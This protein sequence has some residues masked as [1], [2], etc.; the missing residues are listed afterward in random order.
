MSNW[1][2]RF[3][4]M[5][6][7]SLSVKIISDNDLCVSCGACLHI[8]PFNNIRME[9]NDYRG[10]WESQVKNS[11][12]CKKCNGKSLC[13]S[14]CPSYSVDYVELARSNEN[15]LLGRI[16]CVCNG[17]S[18]NKDIRFSASTGG[19]VHELCK[20]L[21]D[22]KKIDG[23]ISITHDHGLEYSPKILTD[24][25]LMPNSIYHNINFQNTITL[26]KKAEGKYLL[27]GLPCQITSIE[28]FLRKRKYAHLKEKI[29]AKVSLICGYSFDRKNAKA[30]AHYNNFD[31]EE[32]SYRERGRYRKTRLKNK[33][34]GLL[35]EVF[36]PKNFRERINNMIFFDQFLPQLGCLY[37]IDHICYCADIV[38][39]DAWQKRYSDD[40]IGTN[41]IIC[42]T[43]KGEDLIS[44][45][46]SFK[47]EKGYQE[48]IIEAQS[49]A[50]ALG[51]IG[52]GMKRVKLKGHYF[53]PE[54][55][56]TD[57]LS[58]I[59]RYR[60]K[61]KDL[62]KIKIIKNLLR[63]ERFDAARSLYLFLNLKMVVRYFL[64]KLIKRG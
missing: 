20:T 52:E 40:D 54:R 6:N 10:K 22:N 61:F 53:I 8:C 21:L 50:Y 58:D 63:S 34:S 2:D 27:I 26:L 44:Q 9:F 29:Y 3:E 5:L 48:E 55:R 17:Y 4:D 12:I 30:F 7:N 49:P 41:I 25:H 33:S 15:S 59:Q 62:I 31:L 47:F 23:V 18:R 46:E 51:T 14:V 1:K 56:R 24:I 11:N 57:N 60:F 43:E 32:I 28:L 45:M 39:G 19:F 13:L 16:R 38:V 36:N 35:F 64:R 42:R 37:C